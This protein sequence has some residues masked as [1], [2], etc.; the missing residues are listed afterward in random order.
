MKKPIEVPPLEDDPL[1]ADVIEKNIHTLTRARLENLQERTRE[2][3]LADSITNFSGRMQFV[4]FHVVWFSLWIIVN[5][6][7]IG[8]QP[9]DPFPFGLLTMIVSL[10]AIFLA[11][12]VLI[13]QNRMSVEADRRAELALHIG[14]LTEHEVTRVL[15]M[16]DAMEEKIGLDDNKDSDLVQLEKITKPEDVL[17]AIRRM[18]ERVAAQK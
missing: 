7:W 4:Y 11:T 13:S 15:Q 10:E 17:A 8:I 12:F 9:F 1:L 2:E 5:S 3:K 16:L 6:G 14:L 18:E